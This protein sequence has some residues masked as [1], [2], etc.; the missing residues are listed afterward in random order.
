ASGD[1]AIPYAT[2]A[3]DI[4]QDGA[5]GYRCPRAQ[6]QCVLE[7]SDRRDAGP[8]PS[9]PLRVRCDCLLLVEGMDLSRDRQRAALAPPVRRT[10]RIFREFSPRSVFDGSPGDV[11]RAARASL[12]GGKYYL[13]KERD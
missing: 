1:R 4:P 6:Q 9:H 10:S 8:A 5:G 7:P 13:V 12:F 2:R 3:S 11:E